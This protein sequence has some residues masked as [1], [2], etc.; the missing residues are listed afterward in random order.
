LLHGQEER[1]PADAGYIGADK[2]MRRIGLE[3]A[4]TAR[5][6]KVTQPTKG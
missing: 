4:C 5:Q 1:V 6:F 2:P 3:T